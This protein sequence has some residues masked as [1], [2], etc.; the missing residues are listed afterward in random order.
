MTEVKKQNKNVGRIISYSTGACYFFY[1]GFSLLI[2]YLQ[3]MMISTVEN[4]MGDEIDYFNTMHTI[5]LE[6]LPYLMLLGVGYL[7]FGLFYKKLGSYKFLIN[8]LLAIISVLGVISYTSTISGNETITSEFSSMPDEISGAMDTVLV[9]SYIV[10]FSF[11][12]VPQFI[13]GRKILL[14]DGRN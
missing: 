6:Y 2:V 5:F 4:Q 11:F 14:G 3:K 10:I 7:L 1:G 9:V 12:T 8:I 13:I